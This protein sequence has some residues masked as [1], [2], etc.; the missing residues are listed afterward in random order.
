MAERPYTATDG[1][2]GPA[3]LTEAGDLVALTDRPIDVPGALCDATVPNCGAVVSFCGTVRDHSSAG[4]GVVA[5]EYEAYAEYAAR[6]L[7]AVAAGARARWPHIGRVVI[8]HRVGRLAV[9]EVAVVVCLSTPHRAEA[10]AAASWCID[11]VKRTVPVWKREARAD[12]SVW[13][14][15]C[16]PEGLPA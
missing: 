14:E 13:V 5:L 10:F 1:V 8:V 7:A 4:P 12:G 11:E 2:F 6:R 15:R 16:A 9:G 3:V